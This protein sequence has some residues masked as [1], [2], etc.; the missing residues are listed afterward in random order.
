M[1]AERPQPR[2][3]EGALAVSPN[4][5]TVRI[6]ILLFCLLLSP[7]WAQPGDGISL[8]GPAGAGKGTQ[9]TFLRERYHLR[10]LSPGDLLRKEVKDGSELGKKA[11]IYMDA[12]E[13]VPD[14]LILQIVGGKMDSL[15]P[16][17]GFLLDGFPRSKSQAELLDKALAQRHR[18][19][20][21]VL[22][23]QVKDEVIV[24]RLSQRRVCPK[25]GKSY[26]LAENPPKTEGVCDDDAT[27]LT[28]RS[29]DT[30][31]TIANRLRV[32][33]ESTASVVEYYRAL[34]LVH[35]VDGE[36][37]IELVRQ[38]LESMLDPILRQ[39]VGSP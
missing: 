30:P 17:E 21:A 38:Q 34:G 9:A 29:D 32:Y 10:S 19:I 3:S 18:Q 24:E 6:L 37:A 5:P 11:K 35:E 39:P 13:L 36:R 7:T 15:K 28:Q 23:I 2:K 33:H 12:G 22:L 16:G 4:R 27:P 26:N 31:Q 8:M 25:C 14:E 20:S 1:N